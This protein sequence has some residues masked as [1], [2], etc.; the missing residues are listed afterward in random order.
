MRCRNIHRHWGRVTYPGMSEGKE[1]PV[2][3]L[4]LLITYYII[5]VN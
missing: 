1:L 2:L 4:L 5:T 3:L